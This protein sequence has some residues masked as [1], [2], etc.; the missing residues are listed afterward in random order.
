M[1]GRRVQINLLGPVLLVAFASERASV[2]K[3]GHVGFSAALYYHLFFGYGTEQIQQT[4]S[5]LL[6]A[7]TRSI[8]NITIK[9]VEIVREMLI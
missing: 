3:T 1:L 4:V 9:P 2:K 8:F 6:C 7:S 5:A